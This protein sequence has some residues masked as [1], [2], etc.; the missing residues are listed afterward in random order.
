MQQMNT[1]APPAKDVR[2]VC[3]SHG[4]RLDRLKAVC[5]KLAIE[6]GP[7]NIYHYGALCRAAQFIAGTFEEL[8]YAADRQEFDAKGKTF[9]NIVAERKGTSAPEE[10][11]LIGAHYD[12]HKNSPGANDNG[13]AVAA[14]LELAR[15]A[16]HW[17]RERTL[18]FV[19]FT[20]EE[21]P[22]TR[23]AHMGSRVYARSC[24]ARGDNILGMLCLETIGCCSQQ[25]GSQ[26]LSFRGRLLPRRGD[27]LALVGDRNSRELL[28]RISSAFRSGATVE[29]RALTLPRFLP[30]ARSS[31][32]WSFWQ[33]G[34]QAVMATD[35]GPLRYRHYHKPSDTPDKIDFGFLNRV[36]GSLENVQRRMAFEKTGARRSD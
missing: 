16:S 17:Q 28:G 10:I 32:H 14:L 20:N 11:V 6:I 26:W 34:F 29:A 12:T 7:R 2:G 15:A 5:A 36:V 22:F 19:A 8:G 3:Q 33:E 18:R 1:T 31:D 25:P 35:T 21:K 27:F 30:G 13:S 24:R 4:S 9:A 23:T